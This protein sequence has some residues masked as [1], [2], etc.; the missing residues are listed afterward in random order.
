MRF[1]AIVTLFAVLAGQAIAVP[2]RGNNNNNNNNNNAAAST[3]GQAC[4]QRISGTEADG[5]CNDIGQC[6]VQSPPNIE[7]RFE[8]DQCA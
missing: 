4:T 6:V 1:A 7:Q 5:T 2:A 3:E 8:N